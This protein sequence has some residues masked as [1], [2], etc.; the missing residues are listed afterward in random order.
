MRNFSLS[1]STSARTL[2]ALVLFTAGGCLVVKAASFRPEAT[3]TASQRTLTFADRVAYQRAVEEV[4]WLHRIWPKE[5]P[6]PKPSLDEVMSQEQIQQ[7]V[8]EYL[9]N[10]QLLAD[11]WQRPITPEQ[12]QA[13]I[14]RMANHTRQ[15]EVLRELFA[16][17]GNDPFVVAECVARP[18]L[19]ERL[20]G[21]LQVGSNPPA[22]T[23]SLGSL[24]AKRET[25]SVTTD[26]MNSGYYLPEIAS[27]SVEN[28]AVGCVGN[29]T[30]TSRTD[31]PDQRA[32]HTAV[33]TGTEMI[34]WGG[35][36]GNSRLNTGGRYSPST[37]SWVATT[38][39]NAPDSKW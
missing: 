36:N 22:E 4:Y 6:R 30:A 37:D 20:V 35:S 15:S 32:Y 8:E 38:S 28:P 10:S 39:N 13:E 12:L 14:D 34:I 21:E 25:P 17:L 31:A 26:K 11:Q 2:L 33:W 1:R 29:W 7:K 16:A 5:N 9:R 24:T 23:E 18:I 3:N 19:S 27:S